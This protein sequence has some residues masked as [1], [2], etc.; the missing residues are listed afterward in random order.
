MKNV[1]KEILVLVEWRKWFELNLA[2]GKIIE[3]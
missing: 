2:R 3:E 1:G